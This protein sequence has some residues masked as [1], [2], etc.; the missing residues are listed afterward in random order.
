M[1]DGSDS[2][3]QPAQVVRSEPPPSVLEYRWEDDLIRWELK[4]TPGGTRLT[5]RHTHHERG[6]LPKIAAGWHLCLVVVDRLLDGQP[7][8]RIVGEDAKEYWWEELS[9]AYTAQLEVDPAG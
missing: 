4:P 6:W 7:I 9:D 8:P 3:E 5:L 2:V 1:E